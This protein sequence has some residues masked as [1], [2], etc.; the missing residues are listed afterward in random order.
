M[1]NHHVQTNPV[2]NVAHRAEAIPQHD[3]ADQTYNIDLNL[4]MGKL[5]TK[6]RTINN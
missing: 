5:I 2:H 4:L 3:N 6:L 1:E